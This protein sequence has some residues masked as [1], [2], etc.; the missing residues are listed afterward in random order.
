MSA[1]RKAYKDASAQ[2][3]TLTQPIPLYA[4]QAAQIDKLEEILEE[5]TTT[6]REF[7]IEIS[8]IDMAIGIAD[9]HSL[10]LV[11]FTLQDDAVGNS[12]ILVDSSS[13]GSAEW[14]DLLTSEQTFVEFLAQEAVYRAQRQEQAGYIAEYLAGKPDI[15]VP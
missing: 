12:G 8:G 9:A 13:S 1:L 7:S 4:Q 5:L 3:G 11:P 14:F 2:A 15:S 6:M 10:V